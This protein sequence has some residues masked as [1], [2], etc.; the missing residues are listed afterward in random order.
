MAAYNVEQNV[1]RLILSHFPHTPTEGQR[2]VCVAMSRFLFDGDPRSVFLLRG[3]AGTG[4]TSLVSA[5]IQTLPQVRVNCILL[6]PTGRAAKVISG[7]AR[8]PAYTIHKK[9]Y[10][11]A[12][13]ATGASC[14]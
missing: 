9:I 4:K 11:T 7:Y 3:Y 2:E 12:T 10:M 1:T 6:A 13:D 14:V 8:R 5:L